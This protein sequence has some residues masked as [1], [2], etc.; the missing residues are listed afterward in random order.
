MSVVFLEFFIR[1][2]ED[3]TNAAFPFA[4]SASS[5]DSIHRGCVVVCLRAWLFADGDATQVKQFDAW[6]RYAGTVESATGSQ[7]MIRVALFSG[8][9]DAEQLAMIDSVPGPFGKYTLLVDPAAYPGP[10]RILAFDDS[11]DDGTYTPGERFTV[12]HCPNLPT[13]RGQTV[14]TCEP[15]VIP[16]LLRSA[17]ELPANA[18]EQIAVLHQKMTERIGDVVSLNDQRFA[19]DAVTRG[20]YQPIDFIKHD[21]LSLLMLQPYDPGL[22]PVIFVHGMKGSPRNFQAMIDGL[23]RSKYQPWVFYWPTGM[24]VE[25]SSWVLDDMLDHLHNRYHFARCD[26]V[27]H[28]MGGLVCQHALNL[29]VQEHRPE[30][31][32]DFVSIST[33]W[34]GDDA[35]AVGVAR[36]PIIVPSWRNMVAHLPF[37]TRLFIVPLPTPIRY[38]LFYTIGEHPDPNPEN[39]DD[40]VVTVRSMLRK[41]AVDR[42]SY[43]HGFKQEHTK[44]LSSPEAIAELNQRLGS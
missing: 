42:A 28:S 1:S 15:M 22:T 17:D 25:F 12:L 30:L 8:E 37:L 4:S 6:Y 7:D 5:T 19:P 38:T 33:P 10:Y 40:G 34:N 39:G 29:R 36:L 32:Q 21:G 43:V 9:G 16:D 24:P 14:V 2:A 44:V 23:D 13:D 31:V 26:L 20:I 35:A 41:E 3:K 27:A 18:R 11:D